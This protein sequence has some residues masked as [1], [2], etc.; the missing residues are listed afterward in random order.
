MARIKKLPFDPTETLLAR[1]VTLLQSGIADCEEITPTG[2][3]TWSDVTTPCPEEHYLFPAGW[4]IYSMREPESEAKPPCVIVLCN[5]DA[6]EKSTVIENHWRLDLRVK[7][8]IPRNI[9][10]ATA[11]AVLKRIQIVLTQPVTLDDNTVSHPQNRLS[12]STLHVF[13][14]HKQDNF[15]QTA[16]ARV[17]D[18]QNYPA[19]ELA[20]TV[21][22]T[23]IGS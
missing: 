13:G 9:A 17:Q 5:E 19:L 4:R 23:L 22:C 10:L 1:V 20:T 14:S 7:T 3:P 2:Q 18:E 11:N 6:K 15:E 21:E 12:S 8:L 16:S